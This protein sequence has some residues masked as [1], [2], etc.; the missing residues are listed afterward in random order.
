[1]NFLCEEFLTRPP[2]TDKEHRK[3]RRGEALDQLL[4]AEDCLRAADDHGRSPLGSLGAVTLSASASVLM[5]RGVRKRYNSVSVV[6]RSALPNN[7]PIRGIPERIGMP[8]EFT[9]R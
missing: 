9:S 8:P 7:P 3:R 6:C 1:M 2:R 4:G 5:I